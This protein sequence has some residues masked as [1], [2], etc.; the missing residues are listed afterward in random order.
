MR[1]FMRHVYI[2][3]KAK[4]AQAVRNFIRFYNRKANFGMITT[5]KINRK[6]RY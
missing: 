5:E 3:T 1:S 2:L 6:S 4:V